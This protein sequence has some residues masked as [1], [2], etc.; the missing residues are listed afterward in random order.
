MANLSHLSLSNSA[1]CPSWGTWV[2]VQPA[3]A[4]M[5]TSPRACRQQGPPS[6]SAPPSVWAPYIPGMP[7]TITNAKDDARPAPSRVPS[8]LSHG[9][10]IYTPTQ[11]A[12]G[13][14]NASRSSSNTG[15]SRWQWVSYQFHVALTCLS[16]SMG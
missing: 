6:L 1:S 3:F 5:A 12:H 15:K 13:A 14:S 11:L 9:G 16:Y 10:M 8:F 7:Q 2:Q 4:P